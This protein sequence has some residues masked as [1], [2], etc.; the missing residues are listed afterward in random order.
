MKGGL[1]F[2]NCPLAYRALLPVYDKHKV[3]EN[4]ITDIENCYGCRRANRNAR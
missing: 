3:R 1:E 4:M 2:K